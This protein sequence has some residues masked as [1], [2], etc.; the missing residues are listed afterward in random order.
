MEIGFCKDQWPEYFMKVLVYFLLWSLFYFWTC[1]TERVLISYYIFTAINEVFLSKWTHYL[2]SVCTRCSYEVYV[3]HLF[4][5]NMILP[6][7]DQIHSKKIGQ[8]GKHKKLT[9]QTF[10]ILFYI[11]MTTVYLHLNNSWHLPDQSG[12]ITW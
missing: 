8:L 9:R 1:V 3:G 6:I 2:N 7:L 5:K 11:T 12:C 4:I 10:C